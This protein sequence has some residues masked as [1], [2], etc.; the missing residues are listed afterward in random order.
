RRLLIRAH[1]DVP[2]KMKSTVYIE[3]ARLEEYLG[4]IDQ[5]RY[6]LSKAKHLTR[7][8]W[9]VFLE[10]VLLEM[11]SN[12]FQSAKEEVDEALKIHP[13]TGR[14]WAVKTQIVHLINTQLG[15]DTSEQVS[16]FIEALQNVPKSGEVWC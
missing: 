13:T 11:R 14:L 5:A 2:E 10:A 3:M 12:D 15:K 9:K 4:N 8:E 1:Q 7:D 16:I 6:Y